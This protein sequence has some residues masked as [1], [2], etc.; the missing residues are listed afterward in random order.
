MLQPSMHQHDDEPSD[1]IYHQFMCIMA[2]RH[3]IMM[4][5]IHVQSGTTLTGIRLCCVCF[6]AGL[7]IMRATR[8]ATNCQL[9][10]YDHAL[11]LLV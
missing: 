8:M 1:E 7:C 9:D 6:C 10:R 2:L 5:S 11:P 3:Q 4:Y